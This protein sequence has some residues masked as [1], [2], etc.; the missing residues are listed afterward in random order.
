MKKSNLLLLANLLVSLSACSILTPDYHQPDVGAPSTTRNGTKIESANPNLSNQDLSQNKWWDKMNDPQLNQLIRDALANN[1]QIQMA[2]GN[3][4]KAQAQLKAAQ[5]SWIPTLNAN[6][7]GFS[8]NSWATNFTPQGSLS[9]NPAMPSG[10]IGNTNFSG[11]YGGFTPSYNF[12]VFANI[13]QT[14]LAKASLALQKA[15][16]SSTRLSIIGQVSGGYFMLLGQ[17]QQ[18]K[19][20]QQVI[21][22][23]QTSAQLLQV[24]YNSGFSDKAALIAINQQIASAQAQLP[25]LENSIAQTEN[26]LQLLLGK[27][28][29]AI[30]SSGSIE[31]LS[32]ESMIPANIPSSVLKNRPD[33]IMAEENLKMANADVGLA[34]SVFFPTVSL[35]GMVDGASIA[36]ANLF[37]VGTGFWV[38]QAALSMPILNASSYEEI[39]VAK[40]GYYVAYYNYMQTVKS[41]FADVDNQLTNQQ[42]MNQIYRYTHEARDADAAAL[43][44]AKSKYQSGAKDYLVVL[45]AKLNLDYSEL[46]LNQAKMQQLDSIVQVYQ[47]LAGGYNSEESPTITK[48]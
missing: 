23:L 1:N 13:N 9:Q 32:V 44:I 17:K 7:N 36:L 10:S 3:I 43:Q 14:K 29:G 8:G 22:D 4:L 34:A 46:N 37:S 28:P 25:A 30:A 21:N 40:G 47:S 18:L 48:R 11:Y 6:L 31:K 38:A 33:I 26:A 15:A 42:K 19:L 41:A 12:N 45:N 5:Y 24:K 2:Q 35:T 27:N 39:K 16:L 20:Q